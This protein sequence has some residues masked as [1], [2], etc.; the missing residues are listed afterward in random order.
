MPTAF[1]VGM[2]CAASFQKVTIMKSDCR[3]RKLDAEDPDRFK[4]CPR[5]ASHFSSL[6]HLATRLGQAISAP[7]SKSLE[8]E[9]FG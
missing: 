1:C 6:F 3:R 9:S 7:I 5:P 2:G 8:V 4:N